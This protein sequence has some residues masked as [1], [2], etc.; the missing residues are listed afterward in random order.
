MTVLEQA[1][2]RFA[3]H[4]AS[5]GLLDDPVQV[6]ARVLSTEEAV[7][8]SPFP[9][10]ALLRGKEVMIEATFR[11]ARGHAF[12]DAP[13]HWSGTLREALALP[14]DSSHYRALLL[15]IM[16]AVLRE[17]GLVSGTVHCRNEDIA[18]CGEE[19]A[20]SLWQEF[21]PV[22]VGLVGYQPGLLRGLVGRFGADGVK[23]T[24]LLESNS[25]RVVDGVE[26]WDGTVRAFELVDKTD[27][28]LVTGSTAANG[29]LD[30]LLSHAR[31]R[32]IPLIVFGVTGAA[33]AHLCGLRRL[34]FRAK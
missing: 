15:A 26:I 6:R 23:V 22:R 32:G 34:C 2:T 30:G 18:R 31:D 33:I 29:T 4:L 8:R 12:T 14:L 28:L 17:S 11:E 5:H 19:M 1:I 25:G 13:G 20:E 21:G 3:E 10:L 16:N 27:L 24:D 7:G 9:D